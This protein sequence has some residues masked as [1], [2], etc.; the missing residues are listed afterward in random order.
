MLSKCRPKRRKREKGRLVRERLE[1]RSAKER[2]KLNRRGAFYRFAFVKRSF[3]WVRN[4][5]TA[6]LTKVDAMIGLRPEPLAPKAKLT[7]DSKQ[8]SKG[9]GKEGASTTGI[10]VALVRHEAMATIKNASGTH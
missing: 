8:Q 7:K 1:A 9:T 6:L 4:P 5:W 3:A 2:S 10:V